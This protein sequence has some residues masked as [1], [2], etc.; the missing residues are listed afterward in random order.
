MSLSS[1]T[2]RLSDFKPEKQEYDEVSFRVFSPSIIEYGPKVSENVQIYDIFPKVQY[3]SLYRGTVFCIDKYCTQGNEC[4]FLR[5]L[6]VL[7]P[8][9]IETQDSKNQQRL[10]KY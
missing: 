1:V 6:F 9:V 2:R 3:L 7:K 4:P 5:L 8:F 10:I